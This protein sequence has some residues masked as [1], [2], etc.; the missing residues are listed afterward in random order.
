MENKA[1]RFENRS[2]HR[3]RP[4]KGSRSH[5]WTRRDAAKPQSQT[6]VLRTAGER[7]KAECY[8]CG[9][10]GDFAREC[11]SQPKQESAGNP[12]PR[13]LSNDV[14]QD[15]RQGGAFSAWVHALVCTLAN[16]GR[17]KC[18]GGFFG[19]RSEAL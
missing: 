6:P 13:P 16:D 10:K 14:R 3:S 9:N 2:D 19:P 15:R 1:V 5:L 18:T 11:R 12:M 17:L 4:Q 7:S 8:K